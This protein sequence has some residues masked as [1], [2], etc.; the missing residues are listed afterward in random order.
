MSSLKL[1]IMGSMVELQAQFYNSLDELADPTAVTALIRQPDGTEVDLTGSIQN[2]SVG[3]YKIP[4]LVEHNGL[5][6]YRIAGTGT[7]EMAGEGQFLGQ[8]NFPVEV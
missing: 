8:T 5:H 1:R 2:P 4:Y 3:V 7:I 6:Q